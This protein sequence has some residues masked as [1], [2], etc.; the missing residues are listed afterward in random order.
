MR[1]EVDKKLMNLLFLAIWG[2]QSFLNCEQGSLELTSVLQQLF[3]LQVL[4]MHVY[5][6]VL[7]LN[8]NYE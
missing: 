4:S 1:F 2:L 3:V 7:F 5:T 8:L 6:H